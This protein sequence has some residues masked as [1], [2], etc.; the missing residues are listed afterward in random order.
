MFTSFN[1]YICHLMFISFIFTWARPQRTEEGSLGD[2]TALLTPLNT[3]IKVK[4][5]SVVLILVLGRVS[6]VPC[7]PFV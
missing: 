6:V 2:P 1:V 4:V 5:A 3:N 7:G